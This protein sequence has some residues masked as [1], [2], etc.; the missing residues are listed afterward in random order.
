M[1]DSG[2]RKGAFE[3]QEVAIVASTDDQVLRLCDSCQLWR[4][5]G[6]AAVVRAD[7]QTACGK[8]RQQLLLSGTF[9]V[10]GKAKLM[11]GVTENCGE[12][13]FVIGGC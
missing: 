4:V 2:S 8:Q 5:G 1:Q 3:P 13:G 7:H 12:T 9:E 11:S 10:T 6:W